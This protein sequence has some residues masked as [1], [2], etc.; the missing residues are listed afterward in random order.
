MSKEVYNTFNS[1]TI[2]DS[3]KLE[4]NMEESE[5]PFSPRKNNTY[6]WFKFFSYHQETGQLLMII[7]LN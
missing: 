5:V 4:K 3:M 6:F 2:A 1:S 7:G